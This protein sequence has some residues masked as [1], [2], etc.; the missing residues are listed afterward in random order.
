MR[1]T[2]AW[3]TTLILLVTAC[4][5][6]PADQTGQ[7]QQDLEFLAKKLPARHPDFYRDL[8]PEEFARA[9]DSL[10]KDL[11]DISE[12][13]FRIRLSQL[14]AMAGDSHTSLDCTQNGGRV[15]PIS[16]YDFADGL[17]VITAAKPYRQVIGSR[18]LAINDRPIEE[19]LEC[20]DT[21]FAA[22]NDAIRRNQR[23][24]LLVY[25]DALLG[26]G[27]VDDSAK[28]TITITKDGG[29]SSTL[30]LTTMKSRS[31]LG[32]EMVS[33]ADRHGLNMPISL[34]NPRS[35]YW[36]TYLADH[37]T[38]FVQYNKC[39]NK[40]LDPFENFSR[41]V[42]NESENKTAQKLVI[43]LR[44]NG[45][46]NSSIASPFINELSRHEVFG[47]PGGLY[48]I[49]GRKTYSSALINAVRLKE[50]CHA[51]LVGEDT[52]GAPNHF[53][54]VRSFTLPN[55][56]LKVNYSTK[57]FHMKPGEPGRTLRPDILV[58]PTWNALAVGR[59]EALQ[60]C[61]DGG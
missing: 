36:S 34:R 55:T 53:G 45:G 21:L 27:I 17:R 6:L 35:F 32:P 42:L 39:K 15:L 33:F 40:P 9:I 26:L 19:V 49:I 58:P 13:E 38:M 3:S 52:G 23:A 1:F 59:D 51:I 24:R 5:T 28:I 46:G 18:L 7:F 54:E 29:E 14:V 2:P 30:P 47:K 22:E 4:R 48:L 10:E 60:A 8:K 12:P 41:R 20:I 11:P 44:N 25:C 57:Y 56:G 50:K 37:K 61:L 43:D 16:V 31:F